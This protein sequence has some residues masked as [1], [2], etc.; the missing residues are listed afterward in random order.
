M[1]DIR[2]KASL[3]PKDFFFLYP[4][5]QSRIAPSPITLRHLGNGQKSWCLRGDEGVEHGHTLHP[6]HHPA[7]D[8]PTSSYTLP[9]SSAEYCSLPYNR[10]LLSPS[11]DPRMSFTAYATLTSLQVRAPAAYLVN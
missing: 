9:S 2:S 8:T 11:H 3:S 10:L 7:V 4:Y 5:K 1:T 6:I